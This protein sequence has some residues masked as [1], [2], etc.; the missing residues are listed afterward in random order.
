[1]YRSLI[2]R[3]H[4]I[5]TL[6]ICAALGHA[7][8]QGTVSFASPS[9][10]SLTVLSNKSCQ[11]DLNLTDDQLKKIN[12][13]LDEVRKKFGMRVQG[14]MTIMSSGSGKQGPAI[15]AEVSKTVFPHLK[16]AQRARISQ[17]KLQ[18]HGERG[19]LEPG[20][21]TAL[22]LR[23]PQIKAIKQIFSTADSETS[24]LFSNG[25]FQMSPEVTKKL[26]QIRM[27]ANSQARA[28][29]DATQEKAYAAMLGP[30]LVRLPR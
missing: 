30:K 26:E 11:K 7:L 10:T 1:M 29:L 24:A 25:T 2:M 17:L 3:L 16:P 22:K 13:L 15:D 12:P 27:K 14:G 9:P 4:G 18:I 19:L 6:L 28:T 23:E 8:G 21:K 20:L 5:L